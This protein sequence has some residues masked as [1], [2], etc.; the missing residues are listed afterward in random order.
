[1]EL[2]Q[3]V[4]KCDGTKISNFIFCRTFVISSLSPSFV[5]RAAALHVPNFPACTRS[6]S[7]SLAEKNA[8]GENR[9]ENTFLNAAIGAWWA[10]MSDKVTTDYVENSL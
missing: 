3:L 4:S 5:H 10:R 7:V 2:V 9:G 1:M 6:Q 8:S